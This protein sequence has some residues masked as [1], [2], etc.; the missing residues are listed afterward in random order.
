MMSSLVALV[1]ALSLIVIGIS[2]TRAAA[3]PSASDWLR[4]STTAQGQLLTKLQDKLVSDYGQTPG[5]YDYSVVKKLRVSGTLNAADYTALRNS[6]YAGTS[7]EELD[8]SGVLDSSMQALNGMTALTDVSLPPVASLPTANTFSGDT[9]LQNI[10]VAAETFN[11]GGS[12]ATTFFNGATSLQRITFLHTTRPNST[13][14]SLNTWSGSNNSDPEARVVTAVVPDPTRGDY[15][16]AVFTQYFSN[17]TTSGTAADRDEL[18]TV[19]DEASAIAEVDAAAPYRWT[20]LQQ[21]LTS[22]TSVHGDATATAAEI[23]RARLVL[24]TAIEKVGT[25]DLGISLK[26][27]HGA[28]VTLGWKNGT[29]QHYAEFVQHP[30]AKVASLSDNDWDVYVPTVPLPYVAQNVATAVIHGQTDKVAKI[31]TMNAAANTNNTQYTL[32]LEPLADRVD[33]SLSIPGL[34]AGDNR[35]LY[36]NADDTGVINLEVGEHFDLDTIRT[37]QAQ[38]DQVNNLFIEPDY[39]FDVSGSSISTQNIGFDGRRQLR[40]NATQPGVSVI[41]IT[42]GPLHYLNVND[43][44]VPGNQN[45]SFNGIDPQ[46]TGLAVIRVSD[47]QEEAGTFDTGFTVRNE[48]DTYYFDKTLG[49]RDFSFTPDPGTSVRVHDPLNISAWG[50]GWNS[51]QAAPDG[52]FTVKLK[53]G[54]SIVELTNG[55]KT[56]YRVVRAKGV[57]LAITNS[58]RPGEPLFLGDVAQVSITGI[59]GGIEKM[60]GIYNPAFYAGTKPQVTYYDDATQI[61]SNMGGQYTTATTTF[62]VSYT[63]AGASDRGLEGDMFIGGLGSEWPYH[64]MLPLSGKPANLAAVAIGPYHF[65]GMPQLYIFGNEVSTTPGPLGEPGNLQAT[66]G[67]ESAEIS[68]T[69]PSSTGGLTIRGYNVRY[70]SDGGASWQSKTIAPAATTSLTGLSNGTEYKLQIAAINS[71]GIGA[72]SSFATVTPSSVPDAPTGVQLTPSYTAIHATWDAPADDGG[73]AIS[74]YRVRYSDDAGLNWTE[75]PDLGSTTATDITG[76]VNDT[77]YQVQVAAINSDGV[78]AWSNVATA[79]P[80]KTP[81]VLGT[82]AVQDL[83]RTSATI[84]TGVEAGDLDQSVVVEY[85]TNSDHSDSTESA[86]SVVTG[87]DTS[88]VAIPLSPLDLNTTYYYRVVATASDSDVVASGWSSFK[89]DKIGASVG[90]PSA[91]NVTQTAAEISAEVTAGD[92]AQDVTVEYT[93][94]LDHSGA[95]SSAATAVA[96]GSPAGP[97]AIDLG[98]LTSNTTYYY[99][100]VVTAS[101]ADVVASGWSSFKTVKVAADVGT[102]SV[103]AITQTAAT[104]SASVTAG[105]LSQSVTVEYST[106]ADHSGAATSAATALAGGSPAGTVATPLSG[107]ASN[108]T[109][110]YRVVVTASDADVVASGWSSFKTAKVAASVAAPSVSSITQSSAKVASSVTAGDLAQSVSVEYTTHADHSLVTTSLG[111]SL[112][113]G[114]TATIEIPLASLDSNTTYYYRVVSTATDSD[115]VGSAWSSFKT[116]TVPASVGAPSVASITTSS[117]SVSAPIT[118]GDLAQSVLVQYSA[119]ADH[120]GAI[121]TAAT[122]VSAGASAT[123]VTIPLSGLNSNTTYHYRV[124]TTASD[125]SVVASGWGSFATGKIAASVGAPSVSAVGTKSASISSVVTTGDLAQDVFVQYT[126]NADHSG[127]LSSPTTALAGGSGTSTV[128]TALS[129]L[130]PAT[131]YQYRVVLLAT[132]N[133]RTYSDW[134]S[135]TTTA[136]DAPTLSL[137]TD[138]ASVTVGDVI[139]LNWTATGADTLIAG[140]DWS[141]LKTPSGFENVVASRAGTLTFTLSASGE[142]GTT[143]ASISV[144]VAE[145]PVTLPA[146][147]LTVKL[148]RSKLRRGATQRVTVSGLAAGERATLSYGG[149]KLAVLTAS[150]RGTITKSF[151]VGRR[152][153]TRTVKVVGST[154]NRTGSKKFKVTR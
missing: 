137:T 29:A 123:T 117:A 69:A 79:T 141:S 36:T 81:A 63:L 17:V 154:K 15:D 98:G 99:R 23:Y 5:S 93:T 144:N 24:Q 70:S 147:K 86:A 101:D 54:R 77:A 38:L 105:D 47:P 10:V 80:F 145:A 133:E 153:G 68:W 90:S 150:A 121:S 32:A 71:G 43:T 103:G 16:E 62:T 97:V 109:Y 73:L 20:L 7:I 6:T 75:L 120:S 130:A 146:K 53:A 9:N 127:A 64:R 116:S 8:L 18:Q 100:V 14:L 115:T 11:F 55:G 126:T 135:F 152:A 52:S 59:E 66:G 106:H 51:Y 13:N 84:V 4:I 149:K 124:L 143:S 91:S 61:Q 118:A 19:I 92:L 39:T 56:V 28:D 129:G 42:Y 85:S 125:E 76:L 140:G 78:G 48:L 136:I 57:D 104:V 33:T 21:A 122:A 67:D 37:Q 138:S 139:R 3:A 49:S 65:G 27:T 58:S 30:L 151:K 132:D 119:S 107:L 1:L 34:A 40:I 111:V 108:T 35:G 95:V 50:S 89:T 148:K 12:S 87:G 114:G 134:S 41:K 94:Q 113:A 22:A 74:G 96:A 60:G 2:A 72:Y 25:A 128:T 82:P 46:N 31:F 44:G 131:E 88:S 45:W 102:P 83:T 110:Y 112:A 26:V 142:G